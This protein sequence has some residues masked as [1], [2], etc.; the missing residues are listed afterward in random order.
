MNNKQHFQ[1]TNSNSLRGCNFRTLPIK[2]DFLM[3]IKILAY[4]ICKLT[5]FTSMTGKVLIKLVTVACISNFV[6]TLFFALFPQKRQIYLYQASQSQIFDIFNM[7][8]INPI[9]FIGISFIV[10]LQIKLLESTYK[11]DM[12]LWMNCTCELSEHIINARICTS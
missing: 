11:V 3:R 12:M 4:K 7:F 10:I 6:K 8:G 2:I 1:C 9:S 5:S